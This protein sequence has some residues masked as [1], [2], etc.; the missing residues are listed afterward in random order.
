MIKC[1]L[2]SIETDTDRKMVHSDCNYILYQAV[3]TS[4]SAGKI[5]FFNVCVLKYF[6]MYMYVVSGASA[7]SLKWKQEELQF[8]RLH[9]SKL[10]VATRCG[11]CSLCSLLNKGVIG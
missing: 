5:V 11:H 6:L 8:Q 2:I 9:I 4:I 3:N 1:K 10:K 7:D